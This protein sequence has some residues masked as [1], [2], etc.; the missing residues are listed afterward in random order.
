MRKRHNESFILNGKM[1]RKT[2]HFHV[3]GTSWYPVLEIATLPELLSNVHIMGCT[4]HREGV[5][6]S[7]PDGATKG[8]GF[9]TA[10]MVVRNGVTI[11]PRNKKNRD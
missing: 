5:H 3:S 1:H 10:K 7:V 6:L 8:D 2:L 9:A 11:D 4:F